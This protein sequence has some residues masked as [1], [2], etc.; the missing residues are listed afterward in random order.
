MKWE[1]CLSQEFEASLR[2][3]V[4][5]SQRQERKYK[6]KEVVMKANDTLKDRKLSPT[7]NGFRRSDIHFSDIHFKGPQKSERCSKINIFENSS[8][9]YVCK[10][11]H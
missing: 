9:K 11:V 3:I 4:R 5:L 7:L 1:D 10:R 8:V 6:P 2:N